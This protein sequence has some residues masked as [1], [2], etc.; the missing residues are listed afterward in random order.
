MP[1]CSNIPQQSLTWAALLPESAPL[2]VLLHLYHSYCCLLAWP[3]LPDRALPLP[4]RA[5][6]GAPW[7][8]LVGALGTGSSVASCSSPPTPP[9]R[10]M[11]FWASMYIIRSRT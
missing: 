9:L 3:P 11:V 2:T 5:V 7:P 8:W 1:L 10:L 6:D 4:L